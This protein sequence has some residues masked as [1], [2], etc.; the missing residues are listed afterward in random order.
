MAEFLGISVSFGTGK[1][2][3]FDAAGV[4]VLA[5]PTP[6][7]PRKPK[8]PFVPRF[9]PFARLVWWAR[10]PRAWVFGSAWTRS[11]PPLPAS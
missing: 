2:L 3:R 4:A 6:R 5:A 1:P 8:P 10:R 7:G 11:T 9:E